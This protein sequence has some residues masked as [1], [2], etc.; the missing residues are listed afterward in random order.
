MLWNLLGIGL[1]VLML[2]ACNST[3][4]RVSSAKAAAEAYSTG[5]Y[6]IGSEDILGTDL[7]IAYA[8]GVRCCFG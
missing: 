4:S 5:D 3:D 6:K 7:V 8:I 2:A 1:S